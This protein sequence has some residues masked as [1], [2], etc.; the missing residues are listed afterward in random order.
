MKKPPSDVESILKNRELVWGRVFSK[1]MAH[2]YLAE[3]LREP[4]PVEPAEQ[5][6]HPRT[7][8][9]EIRLTL[10]TI[11]K[12]QSWADVRRLLA[13]TVHK[14]RR[15]SRRARIVSSALALL[16]ILLCYHFIANHSAQTTA[17]ATGI[18]N[19]PALT[20]GTPNYA[21][22]LP[23]GKNI[24]QLGGWTRI[25]PKGK[26]PVY[27]YAD[28]INGTSVDVSEQPLPPG[29]EKNPDDEVAQLAK[30]FNAT[31]KI[32]AADTNIY[33]ATFS[34][35]SQSVIGYKDNVLLLM[36]SNALLPPT[37]WVAYVDTLQ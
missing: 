28:Q 16:G 27:A 32:P 30:N 12:V 34:D 31:E 1:L 6:R 13:G 10:P 17:N 19:P 21:T 14:I 8:T 22:V 15:S 18:A 36:K 29:F 24:Q 9:I 37:K 4:K 7:K 20:K 25:S 26:N 2:T 35:N 5:V 33:I 23:A 3:S 11:P